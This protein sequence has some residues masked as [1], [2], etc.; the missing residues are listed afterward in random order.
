MKKINLHIVFIGILFILSLFYLN[1]VLHKGAILNNIHYINDLTFLSYNTLLTLKNNELPLWTPYFYSGQPLLAIP[2]SYMFDLNFLFIYLFRDIYAA[3]NLSLVLY[4]FFAG[5][6][7]YILACTIIGSKKAAFI[8]ALLY[9]FNGFVQTFVIHGHINIL[10]GYAL[11]PFIFLFV[12]RA[13]KSTS[14]I[15]YS[16]LAGIFFAL[17][18]FA[19]SMILFFYTALLV[20]V[21]LAINLISKNF[22]S[23]LIKSFFVGMILVI[24]CLSLASVKLLPVLEF[25]KLSSRSDK[26]SYS[27]YIGEPIS[28]R[29]FSGTFIG[30][31]GYAGM[32]GAVGV[33]G[34]ILILLGFFS[35][36]K[37]IVLFALFL[38]IFSLLLASG[39]F[40]A[41][42]MYKVPGFDKLRHVERAMVL[43]VFAASIL[44]AYGFEYLSKKMEKLKFYLRY[45]NLIFAVVILVILLEL[46]FV[47][48]VPQSRKVVEPKDIQLL[49]YLSKDS[50]DFRTINL[51][52]QDIIGAAGYNYYAQ[53]GIP[54]VK[55]GG[56]IWV[57][58][59]VEFVG[60]AQ[61]YL[62][63]K[64]LGILNVKYIIAE[65]KFEANN[66]SLIERFNPCK[67]CAVW[68]AFGPYLYKNEYFLP[69]YYI[70][71]NSAL[72]IGDDTLVRQ[73]DYSLMFQSFEPKNIVLVEGTKINDYDIDF[74][75]RFNFILLVKGSV[76]EKSIDK[77]K[78]YES[79]GGKIIPDIVKGQNTASN[80]DINSI[81]NSTQ[82]NMAEIKIKGYS[83]NKVTLELN[84]EKGWLVASERF[85]YFPGWKATINGN[86]MQIF[87]A[88]NV[89]TAVYL[90]GQKGQL[91]FEYSPDSYKTGKL[92][93]TISALIIIIYLAYFAY[94]KKSKSKIKP[95][96]TNQA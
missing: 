89:I 87:K 30:D 51:A 67:E 28:F 6:G 14:W 60:I 36:K 25:T 21:Y 78:S 17:Q 46:V 54:E 5:L 62:N 81:F 29:D 40:V 65:N 76:D 61:Q 72:V 35:H 18:I 12:Y 15:F 88:D 74:L 64:M 71:P 43:F 9:M 86:E 24:V 77:L 16:I 58:N 32:S 68:N 11:I 53:E 3:M 41:N 79:Q 7:M 66:F 59:Y 50:S 70:V 23:I 45:K 44:A 4:F 94:S 33:A 20:L 56:G 42:F 82:G 48:N 90:D 38:M 52:Q 34:I 2:E 83:N 31:F 85:A 75:K 49:D 22:K 13:M 26:V 47:Q 69:R 91:V 19:G 93:T 84:G 10:E 55:G 96:D 92:I 39:T 8:S 37:R 57:N 27:E 80:D 73:L 95:G 63:S 1:G